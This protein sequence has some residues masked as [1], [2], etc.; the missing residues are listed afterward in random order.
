MFSTSIKLKKCGVIESESLLPASKAPARSEAVTG[1]NCSSL[2]REETRFFN[3]HFQSF[4]FST[5]RPA[6]ARA[7]EKQSDF[8]PI[9]VLETFYLA[10][11]LN[12]NPHLSIDGM[13]ETVETSKLAR[14][15]ISK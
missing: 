2:A 8:A 10:W 6:S 14:K 7:R 9:S 15:E 11:T 12:G 1:I 4:H 5:G 13:T 3:C